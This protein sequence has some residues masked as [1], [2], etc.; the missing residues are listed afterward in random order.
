MANGVKRISRLANQMVFLAR[1]DKTDFSDK[2]PVP[3]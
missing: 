3:I 2:I 1:E